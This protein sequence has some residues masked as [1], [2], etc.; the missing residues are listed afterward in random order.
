MS[1]SLGPLVYKFSQV[2]ITVCEG[3]WSYG[4]CPSNMGSIKEWNEDK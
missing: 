2:L 3:S 4:Y 1:L